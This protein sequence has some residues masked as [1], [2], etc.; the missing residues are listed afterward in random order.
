MKRLMFG[1]AATLGLAAFLPGADW[2]QW[3]GPDRGNRITDFTPPQEWPKQLTQKWKVTVGD[4]VASP[5]LVG[6]RLYVFARQGGDEVVMAIEAES[7]KIAWSDK[8]PAPEI[9]GPAGGFKGPRGTP[10]V[11]GGMVC[12]FGT[13]GVVSCCD[14]KDGK[15]A[16]R[17]ETKGTPGF[18]TSY[19]PLIAEGKCIIHSGGGGG[20]G[21]GGKG[22][23]GK[24]EIV[25]YD[26]KDGGESW[27]WSGD[28]PAYAS[29]VLMA[30]K[31]TKIV[32][33]MTE[34]R[35]VG[36]DLANGKLLFQSPFKASRYGNT[37]TP[38]DDG[39]TIIFSA[40]GAGTLAAR[41]EPTADGFNLKE[42][43]KSDQS[44][45]MY[46][47]PILKDGRIYGLA[48]S[49]RGASNL[50]CLDAKTGDVLWVDKTS[51]GECGSVLD[52]GAVL[53][54]L[55]SDSNL[56]AFKPNDKKYDEL[57]K[58]KVAD[59]AT[60]TVPIITGK[61]VFVKDKDSLILWTFE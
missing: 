18:K 54:A 28:P 61:R 15:L 43:W 16:W 31:G 8:Y 22:G 47:S 53:L 23:G 55:S 42:L 36:L 14:A 21:G 5:T 41:V 35:A 17:K 33:A 19:S 1:F 10:A 40:Q 39:D 3:R 27:K 29:P 49:G 25:A 4:G 50:Y 2:P 32:V 58:I 44:P 59:T 38:I 13:S 45:H 34:T 7:G 48:G 37:V 51:R 56:L 30:V 60:W 46:N 6:N 20:K 24:G 9:K 11:A 26:I 52:A 57:A 12:T